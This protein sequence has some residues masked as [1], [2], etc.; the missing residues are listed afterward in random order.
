VRIR[1]GRGERHRRLINGEG[2]AVSMT[3]GQVRKQK[4]RRRTSATGFFGAPLSNYLQR[5]A[6]LLSDGVIGLPVLIATAHS[7]G[8]ASCVCVI[9]ADHTPLP[10]AE[11]VGGIT[12]FDT[13][14][15]RFVSVAVYFVLSAKNASSAV[16]RLRRSDFIAV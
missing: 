4:T 7:A 12:P 14:N 8:E 11:I 15:L 2:R 3:E 5:G 16:T 1:D 10:G 13:W 6:P 9:V